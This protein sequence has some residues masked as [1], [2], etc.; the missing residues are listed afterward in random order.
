MT[1]AHTDRPET[2]YR[3]TVREMPSDDRPRER[4]LNLGAG[5]LK[6]EELLAII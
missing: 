1:V 6:T 5:T 4:L 2:Q 3:V